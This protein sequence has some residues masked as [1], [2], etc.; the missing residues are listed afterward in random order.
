MIAFQ[1]LKKTKMKGIEQA[2]E[3]RTFLHTRVFYVSR[4]AKPIIYLKN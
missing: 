4:T 1:F 2:K 3:Y